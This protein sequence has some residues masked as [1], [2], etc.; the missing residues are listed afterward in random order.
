LD[1]TDL[2]L[3]Y[4]DDEQDDDDEFDELI[5]ICLVDIFFEFCLIILP[6]LNKLEILKLS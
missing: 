3:I 2:I 6:L 1:D 5:H 4:D